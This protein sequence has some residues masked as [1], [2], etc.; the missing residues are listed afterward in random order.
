MQDDANRGELISD[1][2]EDEGAQFLDLMLSV[3]E[4]KDKLKQDIL[5]L[6]NAFIEDFQERITQVD[7]QYLIGPKNYLQYIWTHLQTQNQQSL[8]LLS[9]HHC[10]IH[11]FLY[12]LYKLEYLVQDACTS[13]PQPYPDDEKE[14]LREIKWHQE[15]DLPNVPY[16]KIQNFN[17]QTK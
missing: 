16:S 6:G 9:L 13:S 17:V 15:V 7:T 2:L 12:S 10:N 14:L 11:T 8:L 4:E 5:T 3:M 1:F